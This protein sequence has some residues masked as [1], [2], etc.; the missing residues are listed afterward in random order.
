MVYTGRDYVSI[1]SEE[2]LL[3]VVYTCIQC[4]PLDM[5]RSFIAIFG[6]SPILA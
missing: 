5:L 2:I 4:H 1:D 3:G 6:Q